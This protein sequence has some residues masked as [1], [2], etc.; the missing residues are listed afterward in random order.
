MKARKTVKPTY[1]YRSA[2]CVV[3]INDHVKGMVLSIKS[4]D[5]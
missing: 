2:F 1:E 5:S 4:G 3:Y